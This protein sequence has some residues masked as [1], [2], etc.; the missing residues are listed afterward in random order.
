MW[1]TISSV[2]ISSKNSSESQLWTI[3]FTPG[4]PSN[5]CL[6]IGWGGSVD[7]QYSSLYLSE[8]FLAFLALFGLDQERFFGAEGPAA[9]GSGCDHSSRFSFLSDKNSSSD[10]TSVASII[11]LKP[12]SRKSESS[13]SVSKINSTIS[14]SFRTALMI[15]Y[16]KWKTTMITSSEN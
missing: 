1:S 3:K 2:T 11:S 8:P 15:P 9:S 12:E 13:S 6:L 16:W 5:K 7:A 4:C 14:W 10:H